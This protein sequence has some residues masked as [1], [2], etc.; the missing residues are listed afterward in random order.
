MILPAN[1]SRPDSSEDTTTKRVSDDQTAFV[2][3]PARGG[4]PV[5]EV[6]R[7]LGV[8]EQSFT[9]GSADK[10]KW[11][12]K[13]RRLRQ[14]EEENRKPKKIVADVTLDTHILSRHDLEKAVRSAR[15][16]RLIWHIGDT[17]Q[18][19]MRRADGEKTGHLLPPPEMIRVPT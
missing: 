3:R 18:T 11:V 19:S 4:T 5:N 7:R 6:C 1:F 15:K 16:G 8:S 2:L 9:G 10:R 13:L 14:L 17:D 12:T